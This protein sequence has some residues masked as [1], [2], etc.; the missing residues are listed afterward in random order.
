MFCFHRGFIGNLVPATELGGSFLEPSLLCCLGF[1]RREHLG[2]DI[3]AHKQAVWCQCGPLEL[4]WCPDRSLSPRVLF[5][6]LQ[7]LF[8][9][10][11]HMP[12]IGLQTLMNR[13]QSGYDLFIVVTTLCQEYRQTCLCLSTMSEF[14]D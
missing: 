9:S 11:T 14:I 5:T 3:H 7:I 1:P 4:G 6:V 10:D 13:Q 12:F 2:Q 8:I